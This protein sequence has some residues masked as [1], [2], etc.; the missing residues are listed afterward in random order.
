[1][2]FNLSKPPSHK[3]L[4][5]ALIIVVAELKVI[6]PQVARRLRVLIFADLNAE[7]IANESIERRSKQLPSDRSQVSPMVSRQV[8]SSIFFS[9]FESCF[10]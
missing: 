5:A 10:N 2:S 8:R 3:L 4:R 7:N 1:M 6:D 9:F